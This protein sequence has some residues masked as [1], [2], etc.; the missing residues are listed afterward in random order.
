MRQMNGTTKV[1]LALG[2]VWLVLTVCTV[3]INTTPLWADGWFYRIYQPLPVTSV[4]PGDP[5]TVSLFWARAARRSMR[6]YCSADL[7][8][9]NGGMRVM[10]GEC[11]IEGAYNEFEWEYIVPNN[12]EGP[13]TIEGGVSYRP[14]GIG[15]NLYYSWVSE[16]FNP[17]RAVAYRTDRYSI[18]LLLGVTTHTLRD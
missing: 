8:C 6:G 17:R 2:L 9:A 12:F 16:P 18:R 14:L 4:N 3:I 11:S 1:W 10:D 15:P 7:L 5:G 13:C